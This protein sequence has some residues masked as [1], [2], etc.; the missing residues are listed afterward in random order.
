MKRNGYKQ[1]REGGEFMLT[2]NDKILALRHRHGYTQADLAEKLKI[3]RPSVILRERG[4]R[5][6]TLAEL[7]TLAE[8]FGTTVKDLL[9][10]PPETMQ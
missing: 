2:L 3:S 9:D 4:D 7:Q 6:W 8:M 10:D 1:P 5:S